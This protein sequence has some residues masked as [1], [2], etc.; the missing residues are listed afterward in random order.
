MKAK[1]AELTVE[2]PEPTL[3][4]Y[5]AKPVMACPEGFNVPGVEEICSVA[6]C[7]ARGVVDWSSEFRQNELWLFDS[8]E[9]AWSAVP[10]E[11]RRLCGLYAYRMFE[12]RYFQGK[13]VPSVIPEVNPMPLDGS[14]LKLGYDLVSRECH[15]LVSRTCGGQ[16]GHSPLSCNG[17]AKEVPTNRYC[18]LDTIEEAFAIAPTLEVPGQPLRGEPGPYHIVEVWRQRRA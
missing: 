10:E 14:F 7:M 2:L 13:Q 12:V 11:T 17:L 9:L 6:T 4:G 3:I 15:T 5:F 16:F 18:L 8:P 1:G